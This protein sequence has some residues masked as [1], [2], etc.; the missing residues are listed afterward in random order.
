MQINNIIVLDGLYYTYL[1]LDVM[2]PVAREYV[3]HEL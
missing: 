2:I 3:V 1:V